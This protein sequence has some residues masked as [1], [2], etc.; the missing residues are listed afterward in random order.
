MTG[1]FHFRRSLKRTK[2]SIRINVTLKRV[3]VTTVTVKK[4]TLLRILAELSGRAVCLRPFVCWNCEF[5]SRLE[6]GWLFL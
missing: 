5:E 4:Q 6:Y 2:D 1:K 3:R